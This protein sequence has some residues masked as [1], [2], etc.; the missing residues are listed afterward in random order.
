MKK[1]EDLLKESIDILLNKRNED[2]IW[3][4][5]LSDSA[6][7]VAVSITA[8]NFKDPEKYRHHIKM[9]LNWLYRN[10]NNDGGFGDS[11][12][13]PSNVSTSLLSFAAVSACS[14]VE[15]VRSEKMMQGINAYLKSSNIDA[16][17]DD[18]IQRILDHYQDDLTFSVPILT[19]CAL[20]GIPGDEAFE[21]I[22]QLPFELSLMPRSIY[23]VLNLSVVSYAIPAL[24]AVGIA[25]FRHKRRKNPLMKW[26][27][28]ASVA[29]A[30]K[31]LQ[32]LQPES[33]GY[34]E[35]MPLTAFVSLCLIRSG[36]ENHPVV[37]KGLKFLEDT[38]RHDGGWPIDIDLS[39]WVTTLS[40]KALTSGSDMSLFPD[41]RAKISHHLRSIQS[42]K[43]HP[44]NGT[45][46]GGWGWTSFPGSVPD[47]DDTSGTILALLALHKDQPEQILPEV[48]NGCDWLARLQNK[49]GGLPTFSKGWGKLPFDQSC[50]DITGHAL[51]ALVQTSIV[52]SRQNWKVNG[53]NR[54]IERATRF[55]EV[56]QGSR[57]ELLPLWF[58]N[59]HTPKHQNPV[60]GTAR[61]VSYL[62]GAVQSGYP[63]ERIKERWNKIILK[64]CKFLLSV[65]NDDG[66]WGGDLHIPGTIEETAL[67]LNALSQ[68]P[69][70]A[71]TA[72]AIQWFE[73]KHDLLEF[74]PAPIGLYFASLWYSEELYPVTAFVE[75][76][77]KIHQYKNQLKES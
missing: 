32:K 20:C 66:S 35:A 45:S 26:I 19:M 44:F 6:L 40:V 10:Q 63:D 25:I 28:N 8:F 41:E 4:G 31:L 75:A 47:G 62:N 11:P 39:T 23:R 77:S 33:G 71:E 54:S 5:R 64:G 1:Y 50:C 59:Q 55:L 48:S 21:K 14:W 69:C 22:P 53:W 2:G 18:V 72:R 65:Q 24:I 74:T 12:E 42:L 60:Y 9:G 51:L 52:A 36:Y 27:R 15:E 38:Q 58:G 7:G 67:A 43:T 34:L 3:E 46:A 68:Y 73:T 29:R 16:Y 49:D 17:S 13:S 57:G 61:V 56:R 70:A 30:M 37:T 76:M